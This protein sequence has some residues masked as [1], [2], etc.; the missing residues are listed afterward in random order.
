MPSYAKTYSSL[1]FQAHPIQSC[2]LA[3]LPMKRAL[4]EED[5]KPLTSQ[6]CI[7]VFSMTTYYQAVY[8]IAI[9]I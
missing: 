6:S 8:T 4:T 3:V 2:P 5:S 7:V 9:L 1:E